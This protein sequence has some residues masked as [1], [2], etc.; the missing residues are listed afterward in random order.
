MK[1]KNI[2]WSKGK[3]CD[4]KKM[5]SSHYISKSPA[6][7]CWGFSAL[8]ILVCVFLQGSEFH[9]QLKLTTK[10]PPRSTVLTQ[11]SNEEIFC[12]FASHF[13]VKLCW[14]SLWEV[15]CWGLFTLNVL[16]WLLHWTSLTQC[17]LA[18]L[19]GQKNVISQGPPQW[20][21]T[22]IIVYPI[23]IM[24]NWLPFDYNNKP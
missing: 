9:P 16:L 20:G 12:L 8:N 6:K 24:Y 4:E 2:Q 17:L 1:W 11:I 3:W 18:Y 5:T 7:V 10:W 15:L 23:F 14:G 22:L 19:L 13:Q 21:N